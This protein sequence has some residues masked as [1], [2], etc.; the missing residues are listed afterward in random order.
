MRAEEINMIDETMRDMG[1]V[2]I[3][4]IYIDYPV[5]LVHLEYKKRNDDPMYFIDWAIIHFMN[6]QPK[7]DISLVS[8]IIGMDYRLIQYRIKT[9]TES[10]LVVIENGGYK[11]T[12]AGKVY[13]LSTNFIR[14]VYFYRSKNNRKV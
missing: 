8:K 9:L 13:F 2:V 4:A 5:Y 1:R 12:S 10:G 14:K 11:I 3:G 7:L 6:N